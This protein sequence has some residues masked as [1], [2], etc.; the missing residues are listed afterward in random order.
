M[1]PVL[2]RMS[3]VIRGTRTTLA[4]QPPRRARPLIAGAPL[5]LAAP[6]NFTRGFMIGYFL[7]SRL[8][9]GSCRTDY[10]RN[11]F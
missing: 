3:R 6:N 11:I 2:I 5:T 1:R 9:L 10:Y 4:G 7:E 8:Q